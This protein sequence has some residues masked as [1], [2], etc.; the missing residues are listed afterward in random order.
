MAFYKT[1]E[2]T[3]KKP[4]KR[5]KDLYVLKKRL[6]LN[7]TYHLCGIVG[8]TLEPNRNVLTS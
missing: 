3:E 6:I 8:S 2:R 5:Q 4:G 1:N 7:T